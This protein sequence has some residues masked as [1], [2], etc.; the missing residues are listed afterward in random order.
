MAVEI[1]VVVDIEGAFKDAAKKT[2][3][4]MEPLQK[5]VDK[6]PIKIKFD[7]S[8]DE[9]KSRMSEL[10]T[11]W[12]Q[13]SKSAKFG[14][15]GRLTTEARA[16]VNEYRALTKEAEKF[17][18]SL[19]KTAERAK[20]K[21]KSLNTE[22]DQT[23]SRLVNLLKNS[24]A[25]L[26]IHTASRFLRDIREVTAQFELQKVALGSIIQDTEYANTLFKKIKAAAVES[27]FQIKELVTYTKQ[28][29]AYQIE[30]EKLFDTT[31][32]LAD[33]SAGLGV[34]MGRLILAFGQ[35]RAA[36][37]LRGQ[38]LRQFT[39]AGI[40]LVD[41]LAQ[42]F[43]ELNGRLVT[44]TEVF[45]LISKRAVPFSMIEEIFNDM[46]SA[47]GAFYRMQEKQAETL[48][49]QWNNLKDSISIMYDEIGNTSAVHRAMEGLIS[50][51]KNIMLN[52]RYVASIVKTIAIEFGVLKIATAFLPTLVRNTKMAEKADIAYAKAKTLSNRATKSG[53][54]ILKLQ[55]NS[56][57]AYAKYTKKAANATTQWGRSINRVK[58]FFA[59]NWIALAGAA[60]MG[61]TAA[62]IAA[63][64]RANQLNRELNKIEAEGDIRIEQSTRNFD[65]LAKK[66]LSAADGSKEQSDAVAELKRTYGDLLPE[67][68]KIIDN[69]REMAGDYSAVTDAIRENIRAQVLEQKVE[70]IT[71]DY[72][73]KIGSK[74]GS[75]KKTLKNVFGLS[76]DEV[77]G[78]FETM[79]DAV[80]DGS[81]SFQQTVIEQVEGIEKVFEEYF[82][83]SGMFFSKETGF[84]ELGERTAKNF[85][86][87]LK[88]YDQ[89]ENKI[90][91]VTDEMRKSTGV[92]GL[93]H[94]AFE[95]MQEGL[96][97]IEGVGFTDFAKNEDKI[98]KKIVEWQKLI[99]KMFSD[100]VDQQGPAIG[101]LDIDFD[102]L[103]KLAEELDP[104]FRNS[105][106]GPL[107]RI[108][109]EYEQLVPS[110]QI[111]KYSKM[112][113][114]EISESTGISM[115]NLRRYIKAAGK[116]S[117]EYLKELN[118]SL[119]KL[120]TDASQTRGLMATSPIFNTEDNKRRAE[121]FENEASALQLLIDALSKIITLPEK[122]GKDRL[123]KLREDIS[124]ITNAYKKYV[125]L[126]KY[127]SKEGA[128]SD[129]GTLFPSLKGWQPTYENMIA[130]L[131]GLLGKYS[132]NADATR[133]IRQA[134]ANVKFDKIKDDLDTMLQRM[135]DELKRSE[136]ARNFYNEILGL[137]GDQQLATTLSVSIYGDVGKDFA[138]RMQ[139]QLFD[140]F[141]ELD[142][143]EIAEED[144][145]GLFDAIMGRDFNKL[146][147]YIDL[148]PE[149]LR[150]R[151]RELAKDNEKYNADWITDIMKRY[152]KTKTYEQRITDIQ[153]VEAQKRKEISERTD[154]TPE[155]KKDLTDASKK[156]EARD[157]AEVRREELQNQYAW[158]KSFEDLDGVSTATLDKMI[159][160]LDEY[161]K[162]YGKDL[163]PEQLHAL[164]RAREQAREQKIQRNAYIEAGNAI[165]DYVKARKRANELEKEGLKFKE[166]GITLTDEYLEALDDE[167]RALK[168]LN[169]SINAISNSFSSM[170]SI[171]STIS[172][173]IDP[174]DLSDT[175]AV[176]E[177]ISKAL[178]LV[179]AALTLIS[180]VVTAISANP[181]TLAISAI[182]AG[183]TAIFTIASSRRMNRLN[184]EIR[185]Q[186]RLIEDL[187]ES[188]E[189]LN[190]AMD[191]SFG[192]E[193]VYNLNKMLETLEAEYEAYRKQA[194]A[195]RSKGKKTDEDALRGYEKSARDTLEKMKELRQEASSFFAGSDLASAAESFADAWLSAYEEFGDT[196][197]AIEERM[198]EMVQNIVKKAALSGIAQAV[199]ADWYSSLADIQD[200]NAKTVAEKWK[201]AMALVDPMVQ[202]MNNFA[203]AM[204]AE[205][206]SLRNTTGQFS[207]I[208][209]NIA[210]ATEESI[211]GL[212]AGINTQNFYIS[213]IDASVSAILAIMSGGAQGSSEVPAGV[214][215]TDLMIQYMSTLPSIDQNLA[216]LL[217]KVSSVISPKSAATNTHYIAVK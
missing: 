126:R 74:E 7:L 32:K 186:T 82:G 120:K 80:K 110:D 155:Q 21:T 159:D 11:K 191:K 28:L 144:R 118:D 43:T 160:L 97:Q 141:D 200:W 143:D 19:E 203:S 35:V 1:P 161:I 58:A 31:M 109:K 98:R 121:E 138:E 124:D 79:R 162:K 133:I 129:I 149:N 189:K 163:A 127:K 166:D 154:L 69:L 215:S 177:G 202:G 170:S 158:I 107:Q 181:V 168:N 157:I 195:E 73:K 55:A 165:G 208:A 12:N 194:A 71:T 22:L 179:G 9:I 192:D 164:T 76:S 64:K 156:K 47:G 66:A 145:G 173:I 99:N 23:S 95:D 84:S 180:A 137:T 134:L 52:W 111:T 209:R 178:T 103:F 190:K 17:G 185:D 217:R 45:E 53:S 54:A 46:T 112:K 101:G 122:G 85:R 41:K 13:M 34:D 5:S 75:L 70:Q 87:L 65:R 2:P 59:G 212:T 140:A 30:T 187:E 89:M 174:R 147:E 136:T 211:N 131:E 115:D 184:R 193:Y 123:Q 25:L 117:Q 100:A 26:A 88:Y 196:A 206:V 182:V 176:I 188:Y 132:G 128:L 183:L 104:K 56:L 27:P 197:G 198:T 44:T 148:L 8:A 6:N 90:S 201:E 152:Q 57:H 106:K 18:I 210:G 116:D 91:D 146:E 62:I 50:S 216:E 175:K 51:A 33:I 49:G 78:I 37:V 92:A 172:D 77:S 142:W 167:K 96:S 24:A 83:E 94:D 214:S 68:D 29:S 139:A 213:H 113:L 130:K 39:E 14:S 20:R 151:V 119:N 3:A 40:P 205:G 171:L 102:K 114:M 93:Y 150:K 16:I 86:I 204:Q 108:Q 10:S 60:I 61:L 42:K 4:A 153:N 67:Q 81:L 199:M 72:G 135:A 36:A 48:L 207:G 63:I 169:S 105:I 38:E 15:N 125:E